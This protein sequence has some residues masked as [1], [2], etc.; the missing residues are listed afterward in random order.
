MRL[1]FISIRWAPLMCDIQLAPLELCWRSPLKLCGCVLSAWGVGGSMGDVLSSFG[2]RG[3]SVILMGLLLSS[4]EG[5]HLTYF[6][7]LVSI[8]IRKSSL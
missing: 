2:I 7:D 4:C 3:S 6:N 1:V 8:C 5:L